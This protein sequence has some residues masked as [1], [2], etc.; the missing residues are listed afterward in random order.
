MFLALVIVVDMLAAG[1]LLAGITLVVWFCARRPGRVAIPE[2]RREHTKLEAALQRIRDFTGSQGRFVGTLTEQ[3]RAPLATALVHAELLLASCSEPL[4][5][6]RYAHSLVEDVRHLTG[7]VDSYLRLAVPLAQEDTSLHVPVH[8]HDV[9]LAAL[10]RCRFVASTRDVTL[11]PC[12]ASPSDGAAV[13]VLGD[14]MLLEAMLENLL[15]NGVLSAPRGARVELR[16]EL[17]GDE[18]RVAV[19]HPGAPIDAVEAEEAFRGFFE[20]P[21]PARAVPSAGLSLAIAMRVAEHHHGTISLANVPEGG[22][23]FEVQLPRWSRGV[24]EAS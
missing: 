6:E 2:A 24:R 5:V 8:V 18:V 23:R 19:V 21:A 17:I 12:L 13:E 7:L 22:C 9:V 16:V 11:V 14:A 3:I 1:V 20:V 15:R 4:T 10:H